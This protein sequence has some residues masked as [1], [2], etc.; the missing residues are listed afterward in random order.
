MVKSGFVNFT[1]NEYTW[2]SLDGL[3]CGAALALFLRE[4]QPKRGTLWLISFS[5]VIAA[6]TIW[7]LGFPFGILTR[8]NASRSGVAGCAMALNFYG[9][10]EHF[11][12][13]WNG[14]LACNRTHSEL[15][16]PGIYKLWPLFGSSVSFCLG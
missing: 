11:P 16:L 14:A 2:N 15:A 6:T 3:A 7:I 5:L 8:A 10:A 1:C 9:D 13:G 4:Y 12:A